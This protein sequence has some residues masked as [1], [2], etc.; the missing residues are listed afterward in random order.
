MLG[1]RICK[2]ALPIKGVLKENCQSGRGKWDFLFPAC[3]IWISFL[4]PAPLCI[5]STLR[6][7][8]EAG[9]SYSNSWI[10]FITFQV[11]A[12][13]ASSHPLKDTIISLLVVLAESYEFY[14]H[15]PLFWAHEYQHLVPMHLGPN[16]GVPPELRDSKS[17]QMELPSQG[18]SFISKG[19]LL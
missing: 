9:S 11:L 17:S 2:S 3:F 14:P 8:M 4:L 15:E 19:I 18:L 10:Q 12:Q 5:T 16:P 6:S 7:L 13:S 1:L